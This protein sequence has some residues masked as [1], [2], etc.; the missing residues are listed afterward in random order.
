MPLSYQPT[1]LSLGT[2]MIIVG[3]ARINTSLA[4]QRG[5]GG[6]EPKLGYRE[7]AS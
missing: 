2:L 1:T 7:I 4:F 6:A 5:A 3:I